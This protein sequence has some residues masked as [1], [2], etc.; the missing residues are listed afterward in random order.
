MPVEVIFKRGQDSLKNET[1]VIA[2]F[3]NHCR[4]LAI[5]GLSNSHRS[6]EHKNIL[7]FIQY[8]YVSR[9]W[10]NSKKKWRY[11]A[12]YKGAYDY[13]SE[14]NAESSLAMATL[15]QN[16][17]KRLREETPV[18]PELWPVQD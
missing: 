8:V 16:E 1:V 4:D 9:F 18:N 17:L 15:V 7:S 14:P 10:D 2:V 13:S 3:P 11:R 12:E 6:R 5:E